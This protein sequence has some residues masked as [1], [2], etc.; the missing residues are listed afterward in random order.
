MAS[1]PQSN[2]TPSV[3]MITLYTKKTRLEAQESAASERLEENRLDQDR[4][5]KKLARI[6]NEIDHLGR[7]IATTTAKQLTT[8]LQQQQRQQRD[9]SIYCKDTSTTVHLRKHLQRHRPSPAQ[10]NLPRVPTRACEQ[11]HRAAS[12]MVMG[13]AWTH[14]EIERPLG[15]RDMGGWTAVSYRMGFNVRHLHLEP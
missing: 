13:P 12:T 14:S 7:W 8:I 11:Q 5:A 15:E 2:R 3:R 9:P 6:S 10:L 1:Q 4:H